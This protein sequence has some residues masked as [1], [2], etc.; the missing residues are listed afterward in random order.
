MQA[1][2]VASTASAKRTKFSNGLDSDDDYDGQLPVVTAVAVACDAGEDYEEFDEDEEVAT[3]MDCEE[4][5]QEEFSE[6]EAC[7]SSQ[8][9]SDSPSY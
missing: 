3:L 6:D 7:Q 2:P 9:C 5:M 1:T 8:R 4:E